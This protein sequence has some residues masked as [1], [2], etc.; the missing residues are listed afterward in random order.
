MWCYADEIFM[1]KRQQ[2]TRRLHEKR[3]ANPASLKGPES[4]LACGHRRQFF[5]SVF[6]SDFASQPC[7]RVA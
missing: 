7:E 1:R 6:I 5:R 4:A 3:L 2:T